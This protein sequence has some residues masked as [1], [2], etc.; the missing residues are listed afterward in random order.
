MRRL[1][2][3]IVK[4]K[5]LLSC[6]EGA[7][8][9]EDFPDLDAGII[10]KMESSTASQVHILT[11]ISLM[12]TMPNVIQM[13]KLKYISHPKIGFFVTQ[14]RSPIEQFIGKTVGNML[15]SKYKFVNDLNEGIHFLSQI[16]DLPPQE[17][18]W[19]R[20]EEIR[21]QFVGNASAQH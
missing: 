16:D 9:V 10:S 1:V 8:T 15:K 17:E 4:D 18:M 6:I 13:T 14:S 12:T 3:W 7:L 5:V 21:N 20:V 11:D 2:A 19:K